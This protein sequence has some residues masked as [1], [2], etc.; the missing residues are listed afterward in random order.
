M[1]FRLNNDPTYPFPDVELAETEPNG[2]LAVGGDLTEMRLLKA[3]RQG[4]FPW[5]SEGEPILWWS[6]D[7]RMVLYPQQVK[8]S[9]SLRK[10]LRKGEFQI[11]FD[12]AYNR[13]I[14]ACAGPRKDTPGTWL[15]NEMISAYRRLHELGFAHS[16]EV[17]RDGDLA[18]GLY[19]VAIGG[20]FFGESMFSRI[21]DSSKIALVALC[22]QLLEWGFRLIDCQVYTQHLQSMGAQEIPREQFCQQL[23]I[24][25]NLPGM[26]GHWSSLPR[27]TPNP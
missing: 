4:I 19:G 12:H 9:R 8:V 3:Y 13:V 24:W 1:I 14:K 6:P 7:P 15:V 26:P 25:C 20:V 22:H 10:T 16:V 18:G 23:E 21:T 5:Y 11:S 2:L 27:T 17:W